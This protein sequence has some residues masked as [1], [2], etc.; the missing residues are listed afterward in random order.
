LHL[1]GVTGNPR[2]NAPLTA[3]GLIGFVDVVPDLNAFLACLAEA[4]PPRSDG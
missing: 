4:G 1:L 3:V 2:W